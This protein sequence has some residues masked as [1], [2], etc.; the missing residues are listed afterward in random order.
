M[1]LVTIALFFFVVVVGLGEPAYFYVES[2]FALNGIMMGVFFLLGT[3][4]R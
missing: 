4:L 1:S 3:Y 2:V